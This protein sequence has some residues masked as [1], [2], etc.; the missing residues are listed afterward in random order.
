FITAARDAIASG[1]G[2]GPRLL[3]AGFIDGEGPN[4]IG[5]DTA[6]TPEQALALI[7][8]YA[9]AGFPQIKIYG[10]LKPELVP[11]IAREADLRGMSLTG[12]IP[13]GMDLQHAVESGMDQINHITYV[14]RSMRLQEEGRSKRSEPFDLSR[15][16]RELD[17]ESGRAKQIIRLLKEHGTVVDPTLAVHELSLCPPGRAPEP[18]IAKVAPELAGPLNSMGVPPAMEQAADALFRK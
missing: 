12:H 13:E 4:T 9:D 1:R 3:P 7:R 16:V 15:M 2:L 11:T 17:P 6:S 5:V 14:T 8:R 10:S 18:G